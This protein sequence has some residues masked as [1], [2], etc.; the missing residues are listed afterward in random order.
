MNYAADIMQNTRTRF[1]CQMSTISSKGTRNSTQ[2]IAGQLT[3]DYPDIIIMASECHAHRKTT[4]S[5][6][7]SI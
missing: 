2:L 6:P 3:D 5:R 7:G 1:T 4:P